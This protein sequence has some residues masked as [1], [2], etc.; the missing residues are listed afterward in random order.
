MYKFAPNSASDPSKGLYEKV[1][2][3]YLKSLETP[4]VYESHPNSKKLAI[5]IEPR[6]DDI[7]IAV[8]YN[9]MY[10][11]A[12]RDDATVPDT[13]VS[14]GW[15]FM[16]MT[17][18]EHETAVKAR[19]PNIHFV[20]IESKYI[21]M[22]DGRPNISIDSYNEILLSRQFWEKTIPLPYENICIFQRDCIMYRHIPTV[23]ETYDFA[24]A[25]YGDCINKEVFLKSTPFY[26]PGIN[27]GFSL[28][29]RS[30]MLMCVTGL[31]MEVLA[32]YRN[33]QAGIMKNIH[34]QRY[35]LSEKK[36]VDYVFKLTN[37]D[38]FFS[39]ACELLG[40]LVPDRV[41]CP[42]LAIEMDNPSLYSRQTAVYHGWDKSYQSY[43]TALRHLSE[44]PLFAQFVLPLMGGNQM[45]KPVEETNKS[46]PVYMLPKHL[47]D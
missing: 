39:N 36:M 25:V 4:P 17:Y 35:K 23:F 12:M 16:I 29:K 42:R 22:R 13:I 37:E 19:F 44:S 9:F 3:D 6:Y 8:L 30:A 27:G 43:K 33:A 24:G 34:E 46:S 41:H 5:L 15:N 21:E 31:S 20:P 7:T 14:R 18:A 40:M 1:L 47:C 2:T 32:S 10:F 28:R 26:Y 38:V 45:V 11:M